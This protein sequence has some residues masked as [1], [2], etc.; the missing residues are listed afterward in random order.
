MDTTACLLNRINKSLKRN[1]IGAAS[2]VR[3]Y[4]APLKGKGQLNPLNSPQAR[5]YRCKH[6]MPW[7]AK[8]IKSLSDPAQPRGTA[9]R[10][11]TK[12]T[13]TQRPSHSSLRMLSRWPD[14]GFALPEWREGCAERGNSR[15]RR[16]S[17]YRCR[18]F[19]FLDLCRC[20]RHLMVKA[21][22]L[23]VNLPS[24]GFYQDKYHPVFYCLPR[25]LPRNL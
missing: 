25:N 24:I 1:K 18:H 17:G 16:I 11:P 3:N 6:N 20:C 4:R 14:G 22:P 10:P 13:L 15:H 5:T 23:Y 19:V 21:S 7:E 2:A 9:N 8:M 12:S